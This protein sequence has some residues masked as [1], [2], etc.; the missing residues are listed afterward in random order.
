MIRNAAVVCYFIFAVC[1]GLFQPYIEIR[2]NAGPGDG[3]ET[4]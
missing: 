2:A 1:N 4:L 3:V